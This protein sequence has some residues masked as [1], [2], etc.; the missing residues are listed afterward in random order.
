ML[1]SPDLKAQAKKFP[2]PALDYDG[3][4]EFWVK[5]LDDWKSVVSDEKFAQAMKSKSLIRATLIDKC[6]IML[7]TPTPADESLF[8]QHPI[9]VML[10]YDNLLIGDEHRTGVESEIRGHKC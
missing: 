7:T 1:T 8:V 10:G 2:T 9:S 4:V 6:I 3:V 5:S